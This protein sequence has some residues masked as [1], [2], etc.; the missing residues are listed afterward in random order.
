MKQVD[1]ITI[2][3][4]GG[5]R[6]NPGEAAYGFAVFTGNGDPIYSEGKRLGIATN[7]VAEYSAVINALRYVVT[8]FPDISELQFKLDSLL[9][10]SQMSGKFKIKHPVMR[11]LFITAKGLEAQLHAQIIYSQIPREQNKVADKLVNDALDFKI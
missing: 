6:G 3:G 10:A 11:E 2:F 4:D 7:N 9:I 1:K 5:S 8:N